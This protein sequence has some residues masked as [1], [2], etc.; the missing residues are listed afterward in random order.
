MCKVDKI[1][2]ELSAAPRGDMHSQH[3]AAVYNGGKIATYGYNHRRSHNKG[4]MYSFHAEMHALTKFLALH[5]MHDIK[6]IINDDNIYKSGDISTLQRKLSTNKNFKAL[7]KMKI[8][9]FIMRFNRNG[10]FAQ[11]KPCNICLSYLKLFNINHVYYSTPD[12]IVKEKIR[13]MDYEKYSSFKKNNFDK[14]D[15]A[16][17][18]FMYCYN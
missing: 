2:S 5:D 14:P 4:F 17:K 1:V 12:G 9:I 11:S 7:S 15:D 18:N 10:N 3:V 8:D 16:I 6:N 13:D